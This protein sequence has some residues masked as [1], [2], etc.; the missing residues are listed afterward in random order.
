MKKYFPPSLHILVIL[1]FLS[2]CRNQNNAV[3][4]NLVQNNN[5][6]T[7][8][9]ARHNQC[10]KNDNFK[11]DGTI[12]N[13]DQL[14]KYTTKDTILNISIQKSDYLNCANSLNIDSIIITQKNLHNQT[15]LLI[16]YTCDDTLQSY[17]RITNKKDFLLNNID[18]DESGKMAIA[19]D[20]L[21]D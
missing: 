15:K 11:D 8:N 21:S 12:N 4:K 18:C 16:E 10:P 14:L 5:G 3:K 17:T 2:S 20:G 7:T 13:D 19:L 1:V 9:I 6:T